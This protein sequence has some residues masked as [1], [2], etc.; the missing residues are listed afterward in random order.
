[1]YLGQ[2]WSASRISEHG[3]FHGFITMKKIRESFTVLYST[4]MGQLYVNARGA[5][6][7]HVVR[8]TAPSSTRES[9]KQDSTLS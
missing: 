6:I 2:L 7:N 5:N 4:C 8:C 9:L 1:M 3:I